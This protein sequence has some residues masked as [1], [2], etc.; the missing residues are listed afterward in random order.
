M[1][2]FKDLRVASRSVDDLEEAKNALNESFKRFK[3][4]GQIMA[5]TQF[6]YE[7]AELTRQLAVDQ[8][9]LIDPSP[10]FVT[11]RS[12][13]LGETVE[14]EEVINT[15]KAVRRHPASHPMTFTPTKR[16][17]Q[18]T[19]GQYDLAFAMDLEKILRGQLEPSVFVDHA[20]QALT[21][22]YT[23]TVLDAVDTACTGTDHYGRDLRD[24]VATAVDSTT[25][26]AVLRSLGDV[27]SDVF[28]AGRYYAMFPILGFTGFADAALEEIRKTGMIGYYK[29]AR[30]IILND[31]YNWFYGTGYVPDDRIYLGGAN[32]GAIM[33]ERDVSALDYQGIDTE[34]A[35]LKS[36][37]RVDFGI[38]VL[39]PWKYRVIEIT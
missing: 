19:S 27:N 10:M 28:I 6:Q 26:D 4:V 39:Q 24:S 5:D 23:E 11:R 18:L 15:M 37:F 35:W 16:K 30:V 32:K 22:L 34:K 36:G 14:L 29:G 3:K 20:S 9:N 13:E 2:R 17:Y 7:V 12:A 38:D 25:L 8:F 1:E 31:D 33:L 21:R